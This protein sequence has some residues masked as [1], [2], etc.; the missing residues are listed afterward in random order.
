M[1]SSLA[2]VFSG[3]LVAWPVN[4]DET[5]SKTHSPAAGVV[6]GGAFLLKADAVVQ[7]IGAII[8]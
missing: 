5:G 6:L 4:P 2:K 3:V 1:C 8:I 7:T